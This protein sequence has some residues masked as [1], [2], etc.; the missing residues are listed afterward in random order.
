MVY[1]TYV[2]PALLLMGVL[3]L[4]CVALIVAEKLLVNYGV[5]KIVVD[6]GEQ[7][8]DVEWIILGAAAIDDVFR[9][10]GNRHIAVVVGA[11]LGVAV[12]EFPLE[13]GFAEG[14]I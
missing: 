5:C 12:R 13:S 1:L 10:A 2:L 3:V 6:G 7:T 8:F 4:L 9:P 14:G 11:G